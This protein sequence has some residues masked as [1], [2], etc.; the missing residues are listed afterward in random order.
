MGIYYPVD[1]RVMMVIGRREG[2]PGVP[3][4]LLLD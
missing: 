3:L 1:G 2:S 4:F